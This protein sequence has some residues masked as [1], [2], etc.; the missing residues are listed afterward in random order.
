MPEKNPPSTDPEQG[1]NRWVRGSRPQPE[2]RPLRERTSEEE[3]ARSLIAPADAPL[4]PV[5]PSFAYGNYRMQNSEDADDVAATQGG[6]SPRDPSAPPSYDEVVPSRPTDQPPQYNMARPDGPD[7]LWRAFPSVAPGVSAG[8][9]VP[10]S[11]AAYAAHP[12]PQR[13]NSWGPARPDGP[14]SATAVTL[15]R[16][17]LPRSAN[18]SPA[19]QT[20]T[21]AAKPAVEKTQSPRR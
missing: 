18:N 4:A 11:P 13:S 21:A 3:F 15:A 7:Q 14:N 16:N 1:R 20:S 6:P 5:A 19:A 10:S 2:A 12:L 8:G 9:S 17:P